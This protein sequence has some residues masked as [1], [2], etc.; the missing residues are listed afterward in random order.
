[1][2]LKFFKLFVRDAQDSAGY[3]AEIPANLEAGYRLSG[4]IPYLVRPDIRPDIL[5]RRT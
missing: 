2:I 5:L 3:F 4:R 1:M